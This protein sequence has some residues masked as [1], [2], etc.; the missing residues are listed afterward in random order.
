LIPLLR[1]ISRKKI[2]AEIGV[3]VNPDFSTESHQSWTDDH[4]F[5]RS[6]SNQ[7]R[8]VIGELDK[9]SGDSV[10]ELYAPLGS[11]II[12]TDLRTA[13]T[14]KY[15]CNCALAARISYWNEIYYIC[16][17]L[18]VS[19]DTVAE[20]AGMDNRI[21]SYGTANGLAF[22]GKCLPKDLEAFVS[23][24][25]DIGYDPQLLRSVMEVNETIRKD[26]GERE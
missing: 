15:A 26:R 6:F 11:H 1:K 17:Q 4:D 20:V 7:D 22:D 24:C 8:I 5:A 10:Q 14:I 21:G 23:F 3:C 2:G 9:H 19:S 13:E 18:K 25:Q 12:R 16:R